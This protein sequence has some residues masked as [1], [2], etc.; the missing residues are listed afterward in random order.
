MGDGVHASSDE[1]GNFPVI[2]RKGIHIA[3]LNHTFGTNVFSQSP[4]MNS[5]EDLLWK[6]N[7]I[8]DLDRAKEIADLTI[9]CPH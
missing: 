1:E 7:V 6:E 5:A 2:E 8:R 4:E 3:I 9:L